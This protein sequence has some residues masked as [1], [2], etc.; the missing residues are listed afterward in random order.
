MEVGYPIL[1]ILWALTRLLI[2]D[3][4]NFDYV[5]ES[6]AIDLLRKIR[7]SDSTLAASP[8]PSVSALETFNNLDEPVLSHKGYRYLS[9]IQSL[10]AVSAS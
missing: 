4:G 5:P 8:C 1:R 3:V 6:E 2:G 7:V 10:T 9:A